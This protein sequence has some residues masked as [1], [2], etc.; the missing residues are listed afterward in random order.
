MSGNSRSA[1]T[2][3]T[4][5]DEFDQARQDPIRPGGVSL[6]QAPVDP[7]A[8]AG[9]AE[10]TATT[11]AGDGERPNESASPSALSWLG[12]AVVN[13]LV[14][15]ACSHQSVHPDLLPLTNGETTP[16]TTPGPATSDSDAS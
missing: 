2:G 11:D 9:A 13:G 14:H 12:E 16:A 15:C 10:G 5:A 4:G 8:G 1:A 7:Q 6:V 3:G